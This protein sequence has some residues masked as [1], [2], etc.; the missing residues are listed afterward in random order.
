MA[1]FATPR[2][3]S[4]IPRPSAATRLTPDRTV[5]LPQ[6]YLH[7]G[8]TYATTESCAITTILGSCVAVCLFDAR[9][10]VGGIN[11]FLLPDQCADPAAVGRYAPS[12]TQMLLDRMFALGARPET[13][14]AR[15]VG[16]ANVLSAFKVH[17]PLGERNALAAE[18]VL[19]SAGVLITSR[20]IGGT[21]G[22][23]LVF[24]P[25]EGSTMIRLIG[26]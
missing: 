1:A 2:A 26:R 8:Q 6:V 15:I 25:S 17:P 10:K 7:P 3:S 9:G 13:M 23:K 5:L 24:L 14:T 19:K 18:D 21:H 20:E 16:G 22:R 12:A 11:H 4:V